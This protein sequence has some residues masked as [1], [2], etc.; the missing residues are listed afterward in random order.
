MMVRA[1]KRGFYGGEYRKPGD[2]FECPKEEMGTWMEKVTKANSKQVEEP[3]SGYVPL[4]IPSLM[5]K[6][7]V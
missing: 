6:G 4:E 7:K 3:T 1:L 2:K 5:N